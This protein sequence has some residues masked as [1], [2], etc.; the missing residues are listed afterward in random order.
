MMFYCLFIKIH[1]N[2]AFYWFQTQYIYFFWG[3]CQ[4]SNVKNMGT[5]PFFRDLHQTIRPSYSLTLTIITND[6]YL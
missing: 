5:E 3:Q 4:F 2:N 1:K 6:K